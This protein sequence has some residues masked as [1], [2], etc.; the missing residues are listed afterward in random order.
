MSAKVNLTPILQGQLASFRGYS[1]A[2]RKVDLIVFLAVPAGSGAAVAAAGP[3]IKG[4]GG[5]LGGV[6]VFTALLF[7]MLV[8]VFNL[9]IK[10]RR[11]EGVRPEDELALDIDE[12]FYNVGW[13]VVVGLALVTVMA[14]ASV[15]HAAVE[16]LGA[17]WVGVIIALFLHLIVTVVMAVVRLAAAYEAIA[18]LSPKR[19]GAAATTTGRAA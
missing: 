5:V 15:T 12:L 6:S 3:P 8:N 18:G 19:A 10:L 14:A 4:I 2:T 16:P 13:S 9:S 1:A 7:A 11:D 17:G